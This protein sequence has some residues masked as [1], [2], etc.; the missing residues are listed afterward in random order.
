MSLEAK[1]EALTK[2]IEELP[3]KLAEL[4]GGV[5]VGGAP[6]AAEP[7]KEPAKKAATKKTE[8]AKAADPAPAEPAK[9]A[10]T[11]PVEDGE[12]IKAKIVDFV[13]SYIG[14]MEHG[15]AKQAAE[16]E[17][18]KAVFKSVG[19]AKAGDVPAD[20]AAEVLEKLEKIKAGESVESG[21]S[22]LI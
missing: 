9:E 18:V 2:A 22:S 8:T 12:A 10:A 19:A 4:L 14:G 7:A 3:A 16:A 11:D 1:V 21:A 15:S 6:A 5:T 20:K 17:K 13:R